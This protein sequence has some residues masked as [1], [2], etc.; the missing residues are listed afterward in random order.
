[1]GTGCSGTSPTEGLKSTDSLW[2]GIECLAE[3]KRRRGLS[4]LCDGE[5]EPAVKEDDSERADEGRSAVA[6]TPLSVAFRRA[7]TRA[8]CFKALCKSASI[9]G[10]V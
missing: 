8:L 9:S 1:M 3:A 4:S 10:S 7:S 2:P 5:E 6:G